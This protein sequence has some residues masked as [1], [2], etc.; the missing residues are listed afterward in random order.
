MIHIPPASSRSTVICRSR[1]KMKSDPT[2]SIITPSFNQGTYIEQ[3]IQSVLRQ[4]YA[5]VE[6]IVVDGGSTDGTVDTLK[7]HPHLVWVSEKDRGQADA[8]NKGLAL[9]TGDIIGWVNSDD[10]YHHNI[11]GSVAACFQKTDAQWVVGNLADVFDDGSQVVFRRSPAVTFDALVRDPD[12]VRQQSTFFRR[13]ALTSAGGW[14][15]ERY[16][17]MDYDLW[18]KLAK[19]SPPAMVDENWAYFRNHAAQKSGHVNV[20]R[21]SNEIAAILRREKVAFRLIAYHRTKKAW[22]WA[23][24]QAKERLINLGIVPQR[25]RGRPIRLGK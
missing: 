15:A 21:Q 2:I 6:H 14:N 18:V 7:S 24:G 25:Y 11:F 12:I 13:E 10:Y 23:K 3:T 22:Y 20:L 4:N 1:T 17:A 19:M 5:H 9:S 8:L 16:M